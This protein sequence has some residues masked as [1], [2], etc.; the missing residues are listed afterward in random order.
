MADGKQIDSLAI[1]IEKALRKS[2]QEF[3]DS[4]SV[5]VIEN[6]MDTSYYGFIS[7][8]DPLENIL[9]AN[10][11]PVISNGFIMGGEIARKLNIYTQLPVFSITLPETARVFNE[12]TV[13]IVKKIKENTLDSI[14]NVY[15][16][17]M[18]KNLSA[19]TIAN[20]IYDSIGLTK[21][22][23][24]A[25]VNYKRS[26]ESS[27][28]ANITKAFNPFKRIKELVKKLY[29]RFFGE[30]LKVISETE[31]NRILNMGEFE[32]V[33]QSTGILQDNKRRFWVHSN[34][35]R[36]RASHRQIPSLNPNGVGY[37]EP[38]I[39]PLGPLRYP[40]DPRGSL[41]NIINCRCKIIYKVP[42]EKN[43]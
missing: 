7:I 2:F 28:G 22:Q 43:E 8:F 26:L 39:T 4:I 12:Y 42:G 13:A 32:A 34:D 9:L 29:N 25:L 20:D 3:K 5:S 21:R 15:N 10:L 24:T 40:G 37:D 16:I 18:R 11:T 19:N 38:F 23:S 31:S 27:E 14:L 17:D 1:Y 6:A 30:R 35:E 33:Q 41:A 36:V